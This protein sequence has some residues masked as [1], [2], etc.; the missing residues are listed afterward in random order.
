MTREANK[1]KTQRETASTEE[2]KSV[3]CN[4]WQNAVVECIMA[5]IRLT[6]NYNAKVCAAFLSAQAHAHTSTYRLHA[7]C[8]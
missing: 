1:K 8:K 6:L 4:T 7:S 3:L 2:N 5:H